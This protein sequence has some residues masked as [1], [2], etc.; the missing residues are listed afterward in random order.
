MWR[1][2]L[3]RLLQMVPVVLGTTFLIYVLVF[4]LPGDPIRVLGGDKPM[5]PSVYEALRHH[6]HLDEPLIEQYGRYLLGLFRGDFGE[7]LNG[8][9]VS[10]LMGSSWTVTVQLALTA[11]IFEL[12]MGIT[13]GVW[14]GLRKGGI[15]DSLV[16]SGTTFVIAVPQFVLGYSAQLVFGLKLGLFPTVGT[17]DGWPYSY[18]LPGMILGSLS[19]AYI[20]RLTRTSLIENMRADYV[21]TALAKGLPRRRIVVRHTLRNSLIPVVTYLGIDLG[22]LLAGAIIIEG[23]FNLPGIG[24]QIFLAIQIK[25][26]PTVVGISTFLVLIYLAANLVVDIVYG[27]LDPRIRYE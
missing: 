7:T 25:D 19:L 24:Q 6:Y 26:G 3:R 1:F 22:N 18:L 14:A 23:I 10:S 2:V 13:L 15:V 4:A 20:A 17:D 16:L 8:Q 11:W 12:V 9:S 27:A 5:P 21:R